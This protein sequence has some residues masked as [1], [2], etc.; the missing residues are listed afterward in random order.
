M[1]KTISLVLMLSMLFA[2]TSTAFAVD[3][4]VNLPENV[5]ILENNNDQVVVKVVTETGY[6]I[7]TRDKATNLIIT[8]TYDTDENLVSTTT[9]DASALLNPNVGLNSYYQH[10]FSDVEYDVNTSGRREI[11]VCRNGDEYKTRG[12]SG[13]TALAKAL[14][15]FKYAVDDLN[16][17]EIDFILEVG[18]TT[19]TMVIEAL[20]TAGYAAALTLITGS[21]NA[22]IAL[23]KMYNKLDR[24]IEEFN[25]IP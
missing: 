23:D 12:Y 21:G 19:A 1:K 18:A 5:Y 11:W 15:D 22:V 14:D 17:A 13:G 16:D 24:A 10:T 25:E 8:N 7:A 6:E 4:S 3:S 2:M 9:F 20:V